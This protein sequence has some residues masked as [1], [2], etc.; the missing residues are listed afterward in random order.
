MKSEFI[1]TCFT[2]FS[3][4]FGLNWNRCV[5]MDMMF[6]TNADFRALTAST[7]L[8]K[9]SIGSPPV[10]PVPVAFIAL[11]SRLLHRSLNNSF[12]CEHIGVS[13]RLSEKDSNRIPNGIGRLRREPIC[14]LSGIECNLRPRLLRAGRSRSHL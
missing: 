7:V 13:R 12:I 1:K 5:T 6:T 3:C 14:Y 11:P 10:I 9:S 4:L 2:K 8:S